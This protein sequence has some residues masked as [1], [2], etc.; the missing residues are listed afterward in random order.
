MWPELSEYGPS[1]RFAN[2]S[3]DCRPIAT[4]SRKYSRDGCV[5]ISLEVK[6][7]LAEGIIEPRLSPWRA[8]VVLVKGEN[9]GKRMV[10]DYSQTIN[11]FTQLDAF[12]LPRINEVVNG[13]GQYR[14]FSTTDLCSAYHQVPLRQEEKPYTAFGA[15]GGLYQFTRVPFGITNGVACFQCEMTDF[16]RKEGLAGVFPYLDDITIC[17]KDQEE[18][19]DILECFF[20]AGERRNITYNE[21]KSVFS[22]RRLAILGSIVKEG[23]IRP[24]PERLKPLQELPV[25]NSIKSLNRCKGLFTYYSQWI[26]DRMKPINSSKAFPL[27]TEAVAAFESLKKSIEVSVVTAVD[28]KL[29]FEV[30]TDA[31]EVALVATLNQAERPVAFF[32]RTLQGP[33]VRHLSVEKEAQAIIESIRY[34]KDYFTGKHFS[35]K[36][37]QKSVSY[38]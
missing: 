32:S 29:L 30:E 13:I 34:W 16:V 9:H 27:S 5:L 25:P 6:R 31:S 14:V 2:L 23:E 26:P 1:Q 7:L 33:E 24:D 4:K 19:D 15:G 18:H 10:V 36:T 22:T 38:V 12:P 11:R 3:D 28:E 17:G 8:Q 21:E 37:D 35:L 20:E